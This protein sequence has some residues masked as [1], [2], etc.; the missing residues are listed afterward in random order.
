MSQ[1]VKES[2]KPD[3]IYGMKESRK[4]GLKPFVAFDKEGRAVRINPKNRANHNSYFETQEDP[5]VFRNL[6][7]V[8]AAPDRVAKTTS[9]TQETRE[10]LKNGDIYVYEKDDYYEKINSPYRLT[11]PKSRMQLIV[12]YG[13]DGDNYSKTFNELPPSEDM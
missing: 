11:R 2:W 13:D 9:A 3:K 12:F 1:K 7:H 10:A 8:L 6:A 4:N 5:H